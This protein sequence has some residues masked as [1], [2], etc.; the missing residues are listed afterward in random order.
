V[1]AVHSCAVSDDGAAWC[2]GRN[3]Y[4][5]LGDGSTTDRSTPIPVEGAF[6]FNALEA[7]GS[8]TCGTTPAGDAI[9]WGYNADG[10]LGDGSRQNRLAPT[11]VG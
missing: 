4:G 6:R 8:H 2:W 7:F 5:Q 10:Q 3:V 1:G 11:P 9:C